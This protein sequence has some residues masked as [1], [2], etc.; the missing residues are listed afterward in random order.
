M[1]RIEMLHREV[2]AEQQQAHQQQRLNH[3]LLI[4]HREAPNLVQLVKKGAKKDNCA[5]LWYR[6]IAIPAPWVA[7]P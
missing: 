7:A 6:I 2:P 4:L 5:P 1:D 3:I